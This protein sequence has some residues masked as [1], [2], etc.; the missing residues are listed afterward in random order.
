MSLRFET[1]EA[2]KNDNA[3]KRPRVVPL[4]DQRRGNDRKIT[5]LLSVSVW[6]KLVIKPYR[7]SRIRENKL[8]T[9][10]FRQKG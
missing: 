7:I 10:S 9:L 3:F 1:I 6:G 2:K 5:K 8:A 4:R